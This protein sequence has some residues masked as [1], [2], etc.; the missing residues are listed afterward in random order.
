MNNLYD[1]LEI[2][3]KEIENGADVDTVLFRYPEL[4][5][6]LR[7]ILETSMQAKM[8]AAADPSPDVVRRSRANVMQQAARMREEQLRPSRR[9][10]SVPLRRAVVSLAVVGALFM[11]STGLVQAASTTLPGDN[12]YPVKRT[13]E[14]VHVMFTFNNQAREALEVAH[15]NERLDELNDLF[16]EGRS[17]NVDFAGT[18]MS[19]DGDLWQVSKIPVLISAG[20]DLGTQSVKIGD[21][22]R[23]RGVTQ[24]GGTVMAEHLDFLPAGIPLPEVEDDHSPAA[25]QEKPEDGQQQQ[26]SGEDG[27]GEESGSG[28][29]GQEATKSPQVESKIHEFSRDGV[30]DSFSGNTLVVNGQSMNISSAEIKGAPKIG[31]S[32]KVE[33]YFDANGVF[34]VTKIEFQSSGSD[35]GGSVNEDGNKNNDSNDGGSNN[36]GSDDGGGNDG[37]GDKS[38]SGGGGGDD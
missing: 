27:S 23:V 24:T 29:P 14:D 34:V 33:G 35:G 15:E 12:L 30:V 36:S 4:A 8:L 11:T 3:L 38:G 19:Q 26:N 2:C 6:E 25:G 5:E 28:A 16:T 18:V 1:I 22:V 7:P 10:W 20:T 21:A 9:L 31:G 37:G 13:W 17:A 32:A